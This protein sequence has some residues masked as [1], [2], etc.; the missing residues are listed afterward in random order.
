MLSWIFIELAHWNKS[1]GKHVTS[2]EHVNLIPSQPVLLLL[3][4]TASYGQ[5][6]D[7]NFVVF[8]LTSP[9]LKPLIY[10]MWVC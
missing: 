7:T 2:L 5:A 4:N 1:W 3:F 8:G 9:S 10:L 6:V